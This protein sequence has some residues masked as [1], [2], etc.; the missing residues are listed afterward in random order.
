MRVMKFAEIL[1]ANKEAG[2]ALA[3]ERPYNIAV[4]SNITSNQIKDILEYSLR[5]HN[6][7]AQAQFGDYDNIVQDSEKFKDADLLVL[8]W[9]AANLISGAQYKIELMNAAETSAL[10]DRVRGEM[11]M[12]FKNLE[13]ASLVLMNMFS[14]SLFNSRNL[15]SNNFSLV[16]EALNG[17]ASRN[18]P[19]NTILV[20]VGGVI[21][22]V[23]GSK[24]FDSRFFYSSKSLYTVDFYKEYA[25]HIKP[26]VLSANGLA[27]KA[28]VFDCDNTLWKG[29]LGEDGPDNISMSSQSRDGVVFEEVQSLAL[30]LARNGVL[31]C[32]C[33]KN[34]QKD[35][36]EV[37]ASHPDM[38]IR[39]K[40]LA[41]KKVNW[42]DKVANLRA[43]AKELNIGLDSIV[44]VDDSNFEANLVKESL[45]QVTVLQVPAQLGDYPGMI[46]ENM[47]LFFS[48]SVSA[49]DAKKT[50][51]YKAQ[52]LRD[53]EREKF[54]TVEEYLRSLDMK[55]IIYKNAAGFIPRIA[56]LTQKTNQFNLTTKRY[57]EADIERFINGCGS[58]VFCFGVSDKYDD[59]GI[60]GAVIISVAD[61]IAEVD[62]FLMS[63]RVIG[64]SVELA[65]FDWVVGYFR[66]L[67]VQTVKA[68]YRKTPKNGQV[69][70]FY[71]QFGLKVSE[72][73]ETMKAYEG[74]ISMILTRKPDY[75]VVNEN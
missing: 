2:K 43:I 19:P 51:M 31:L 9:E 52:A 75:L 47:G 69:L 21:S 45:P 15:R 40:D 64:R 72:S 12:V 58:R 65:V 6:I 24:A 66:K 59:S 73:T 46:R 62:T 60:V 37:L 22:R 34:N 49:E 33:S 53:G 20:D 54:H 38:K 36:D 41:L 42:D 7:N 55:I 70:K 74:E 4:L 26:A 1:K 3:S 18:K 32:L 48:L 57:T 35:V 39:D 5:L 44:F 11:D 14:P 71:D 56:Q 13:R 29:I 23:S 61:G 16:C 67:G 25:A 50:G 68:E 27:K 63:C 10:L 30:A 17:H 28:I 8:F